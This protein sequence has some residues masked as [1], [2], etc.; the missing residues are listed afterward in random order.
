VEFDI[1]MF[2][3]FNTIKLT[4]NGNMELYKALY[5]A[6]D[7]DNDFNLDFKELLEVYL[8]IETE[9]GEMNHKEI[10]ELKNNF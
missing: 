8:I 6:F 4:I 2:S 5:S 1:L 7:L 10:L 9:H 3:L